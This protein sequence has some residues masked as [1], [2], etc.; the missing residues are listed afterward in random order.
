[1]QAEH[2]AAA[3]QAHSTKTPMSSL[4]ELGQEMKEVAKEGLV[5]PG[6]TKDIVYDSEQKK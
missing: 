4:K 3:A 1:M 2:E 5:G 6:K